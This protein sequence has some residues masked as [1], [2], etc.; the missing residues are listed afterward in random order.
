MKSIVG[1]T[2]S[3]IH[4]TYLLGIFSIALAKWR[5]PILL[6]YGKALSDNCVRNGEYNLLIKLQNF[7]VPKYWFTHFYI[8]SFVLSTFN[9]YKKNELILWLVQF[10]STRR[11]IESIFITNWGSE[12]RIHLSHYLVGVWFYTVLNLSIIISLNASHNSVPFVFRIIGIIGFVIASIDQFDNHHYLS[13][14]SK[15]TIPTEGLFQWIASAHYFDEMIIY[16]SLI[17]ID[18]RSSYPLLLSFIWIIVN[19][20]VSSVETWKFYKRQYG[21][22]IK[23]CMIPFVL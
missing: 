5:I 4:L 15:Y 8:L 18:S 19:L 1:W 17:L 2:W 10:H 21:V 14:L 9:V 11:L 7:T 20:G 16:G 3:F 22:E 12:S 6:K 23:Y 13:T